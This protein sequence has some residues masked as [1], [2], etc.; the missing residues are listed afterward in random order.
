MEEKEGGT[1][2]TIVWCTREQQVLE[3]RART[4][5]AVREASLAGSLGRMESSRFIR[6]STGGRRTEDPISRALLASCEERR[7]REG[8]G[9]KE[10]GGGREG[11]RE[12]R[13]RKKE[14]R[15]RVDY[16]INGMG[17]ITQSLQYTSCFNYS[18]DFL[19]CIYVS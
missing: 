8:E 18:N 12:G 10:G 14:G 1:C 16:V 7:G 3:V 17:I 15:E 2:R 9:G 13:E 19:T 11:G 6:S 4:C 5:P